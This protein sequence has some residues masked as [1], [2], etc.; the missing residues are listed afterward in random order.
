M[1][2]SAQK[3]NL[4]TSERRCYRELPDLSR[5]FSNDVFPMMSLRAVRTDIS[6]NQERRAEWPFAAYSGA[7]ART[8]DDV[9]G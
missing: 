9:A 4:S 1:E 2:V 3:P 6:V 8:P 5:C 7:L